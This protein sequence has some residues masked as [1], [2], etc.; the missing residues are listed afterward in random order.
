MMSNPSGHKS[1]K[2]AMPIKRLP[3]C[4]NLCPAGE[5]IQRWIS[6]AKEKKFHEAWQVIIQSNPFPAIHGRICYHYCETQCNR[7]QYDETVNIHCIERFLG[8]MALAE[9]WV[10]STNNKMTG[11]K[12]LVVGA[13]PAGLSAAFHLRLMGHDVIIYEALSQAGG[14]M[15]VGIPAYRLPRKILSGE[16]NRI[17]NIGVKIKYNRIVEDV[18]IEKERGGFDAVF[19]AIGAHL[20]KNM[21]F[22]MEN[23]CQIIDAID[24]LREV[25]FAKAPQLGSRL[26]VYGGGN[27]S[28]DVARSAKRLGI[29]EVT[30][31]YYRAREKMSAF[32]HEVEEALEEG[33]K[34]VFLRSITRLDKNTLTL[35]VNDM[36]DKGRPKNTGEIE[37]IETDTLIF[38]LSQIPDSEFLRKIPE[39]E[40]QPNGVVT[41]DNFFMTGY[42]GIFAAGDMIPYDRSVT[43]AVGQGRQAACHID[44][45]LHDTVYSTP[46]HRELAGFD[47]LHISDEKS[48]KT[49]QKILD[50]STRI[51]SFDEILDGCN[52]DEVLYE[53]HRC[54]S[55]G[56]CF[57]CGECYAICPVQVIAHSELDKRVTNIDTENCI[58]CGKCFK[59]CSCGAFVMADRQNN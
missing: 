49:K 29:S 26:V 34:F 13:G 15:L 17:L 45:Y 10:P 7:I 38:A 32:P 36:D 57:G 54:F 5:D 44:A 48:K 11:K 41:V 52:Q 1:K 25:S 24:Y 9:N 39:I 19:L 31:I 8:D 43:V 4:N 14:T 53:T 3:P 51:K 37:K 35:S 21:A 58:G 40:L 50:A 28:I 16:I 18:L 20:G 33:V 59:V 42:R 6:L 46:S 27:T 12:I 47:K 22:P 23:P 30:I 56:N 2:V 55:C